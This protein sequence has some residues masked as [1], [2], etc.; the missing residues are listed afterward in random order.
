MMTHKSVYVIAKVTASDQARLTHCNKTAS[1]FFKVGEGLRSLKF[2]PFTV[3][4]KIKILARCTGRR[5]YLVHLQQISDK[6]IELYASSDKVEIEEDIVNTIV[7]DDL[8]EVIETRTKLVSIIATKP[9]IAPADPYFHVSGA[10]DE[11]FAYADDISKSNP[12]TPVRIMMVGPSG[13]GKTSL[14]QRFAK[15]T[16]RGYFRMNCASVRDPEEWFGYRAAKDG[17]TYFEPS[18]FIKRLVAGN[19]VVVLDE[20]NRLESW[21]LNT[22]YPLMDDDGKTII[23]NT[24]YKIGPNVI[25]VAT[26]NLGY[27][28]TGTFQMDAALSNRFDFF[29]EVGPM[30]MDQEVKVLTSR[31]GISVDDASLIVRIA[32]KVRQ[33]EVVE[34]STRTTLQIARAV[35][36]KMPVRTAYQHVLITRCPA[37]G[38]SNVR[39]NVIDTINTIGGLYISGK[40]S[41][42]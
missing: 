23:N 12:N 1:E 11:I 34:C 42:F 7:V 15:I 14:P 6:D 29:C 16:G 26:I 13:Y 20:F 41:I 8:D 4:D 35:A 33:L 22:L 32:A 39:K 28:Y 38:A 2:N 3:G 5:R 36:S 17:S 24:E 18:E 27:K 10:N 21:L 19:I 9:E 31:Y 40:K 37:D 25:F 30:P